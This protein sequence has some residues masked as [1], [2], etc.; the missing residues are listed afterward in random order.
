MT[1]TILG[2]MLAG[3]LSVLLAAYLP[4]VAT[5]VI[6]ALLAGGGVAFLFLKLTR[7]G[8]P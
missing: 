2:S 7:R 1:K 8:R 3:L 6:A 5:V 4:Q